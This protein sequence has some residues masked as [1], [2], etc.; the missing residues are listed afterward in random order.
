MLSEAHNAGL[1]SNAQYLRGKI[2]GT[3]TKSS[4]CNSKED[5]RSQICK[6]REGDELFLSVLVLGPIQALGG[7]LSESP[8]SGVSNWNSHRLAPHP[9]KLLCET[10]CWTLMPMQIGPGLADEPSLEEHLIL[11]VNSTGSGE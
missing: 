7:S 10:V 3:G 1:E 5:E 4:F 2:A 8:V 11:I 6:V 9:R